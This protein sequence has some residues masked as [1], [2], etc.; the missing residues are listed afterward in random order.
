MKLQKY[1]PISVTTNNSQIS[2]H[3]CM[4]KDLH[5]YN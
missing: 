4:K 1:D 2:I 3:M 5:E